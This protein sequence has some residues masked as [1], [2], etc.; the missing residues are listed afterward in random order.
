MGSCV[1]GPSFPAWL[2]SQNKVDYLDFSNAGISGFVPNWF[3]DMSSNMSYLNISHNELQG[4][5]PTPIPIA[6]FTAVDLS[7]NKFEGPIHLPTVPVSFLDFSHNRFYGAIPRNIMFGIEFLS[8]SH[9]QLQGEIP[10][11]LGKVQSLVVLDLSNNNLTGKVPP[12]LGDCSSLEVLDLG[13]NN[14]FGIIPVSL[15]QLQ[16]LRSLHL[17]NNNFWGTLPLSF[18]NLSNLE[19]ID[20]GN[21]GF[22][23]SIPPWLTD[24][25]A[26]LRILRL[27]SNAFSGGLPLE[28]SKLNAL[29]VLDLAR[30]NLD[31][32]IPPS[33]GH[34]KAIVD[35]R[36]KNK[37]LRYGG[38]EDVYKVYYE[39]SLVVTTKGQSLV[40]TK[41]LSLV[42]S[43]DLSDNNFTGNLPK[44]ITKLSGL[45]V[46]NLSRNHITGQ[47]PEGMSNLHQ[48]SSLDLSHNQLSG[49]IPS[50]LASLSFLGYLDL[51]NN[52]FSGVIPYTG[53]MTTF[54]ES[55]YVG[56][57]G[58]CGPPLLVKCPNDVYPSHDYNKGENNEDANDDRLIDKWF[59]LSLGLGFAAG[60]LIPYLIF[61]IKRSWGGVYFAIMDQVVYK[62]LRLW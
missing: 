55:C 45:V 35:E 60:I 42:T 32:N 48:L 56:N 20:I 2:K 37:Y 53:H 12:S 18:R 34:L 41:T 38:F 1:L 54:D 7:F 31:G 25:F 10:M 4:K 30:N 61:S 59:Y 52:N 14:F 3:W 27:R 11:S 58:L 26:H 24:G 51:S 46:L 40:Y 29:Q 39:E 22:S 44:E 50:S 23:G 43:I 16:R 9:N 47:I 36:K 8:F 5:L 28:L 19:T 33:L 62:I 15:G 17:S 49:M 13:S 57:P 21:N 6:Q